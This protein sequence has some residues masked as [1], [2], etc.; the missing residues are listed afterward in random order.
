MKKSLLVILVLIIIGGILY[1]VSKK[2]APDESTITSFEECA[3]YYPVMESYPEQCNTPGGKHFTRD[4]G[5]ILEKMDLI[6][7]A[8]PRP[9]DV[10]KSPLT[11]TGEAR[12]TWYF[13]ASFPVTLVDDEGV[14]VARGIAEAQGEW[15]TEEFVPFKATLTFTEKPTTEKGRLMLHKDNP[16][17]L[18]QNDDVLI[19]PIVFE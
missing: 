4:V 2:P 7:I 17:G 10:V 6:D 1:F 18:P 16:S 15:M 5:N 8:S 13:E 9:G 14:E 3:K 12:G 19:V 11:V